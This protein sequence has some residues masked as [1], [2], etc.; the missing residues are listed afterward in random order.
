MLQAHI[1]LDETVQAPC[2]LMPGD[3]KRV[4]VIA[5]CL[6]DVQE[7][8]FNR[9]YRSILGTYKGM[10][11]IGISTGMG[12]SSVAI[13]VEELKNIGV[14]TM[15]RIG[16]AGAMQEGIGLGDLVLAEGAIRD[17]GASKAYVEPIY[18][19]VPDYRLIHHCAKVAEEYGWPFHTGIV[20][21]HE[22]FYIDNDQEICEAWSK[23]GVLASDF[24]TAALFTV[25]RIRGVHTAS[26]LNNVVLWGQD[27]AEAVSDYST[28]A[29]KTALGE[30]R[31]VKVAL[32]AMYR[33]QKELKGEQV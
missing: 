10:K 13:A 3:P 17:D 22:S 31:E 14:N 6:E 2:A 11:V 1:H 9:E 4:D 24:E 15:M 27:S 20:L 28:G 32:E 33:L 21:S 29:E 8:T 23:K 12:G 30:E 25:G 19:A 7:L 18:P 5:K 26:I 16:S